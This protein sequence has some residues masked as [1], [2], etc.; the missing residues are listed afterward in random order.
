MTTTDT[1]GSVP[2]SAGPAAPE[3]GPVRFVGPTGRF[4]QLL[5]RGALLLLV[6]LGIYRF[7]FVTDIRRYLWSNTE[8]AGDALEYLG[9][10][11]E[12]LLGFLV[13]IAILVPIYAGFFVAA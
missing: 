1:T 9:T 10:G 5:I 11:R 13:A 4:W 3:R 2:P 8:I 7:W 12:L 6:T